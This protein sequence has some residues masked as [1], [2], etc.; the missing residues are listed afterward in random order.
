MEKPIVNILLELI[1]QYGVECVV[2]SPGS[3]NAALIDVADKKRE[4]KKLIVVD[5]RTAAFVA[6]GISLVSKSPVAVICTSGSALLN[7]APAVAEAYYQGIPLIVI[8]ADRPMEWIDQDDSQTIRQSGALSLITKAS[9]DLN[10]DE[11]AN[12]DYIWYAN[13]VINEGMIK[14][15]ERKSGPVHFNV[16]LD[17]KV[18]ES[19]DVSAQVQHP[20]IQNQLFRKV[21]VLRPAQRLDNQQMRQLA[22]EGFDKK[23]MVVAGFMQPDHRLQKAM[24]LLGT[25]PNVCIMAE[26]VSNLHLSPTCYKVDTV[27]FPMSG[28]YEE[29][30]RP[31]IVISLGGALISRKLKE[32]LRETN[33][34]HWSLSYAENLIDSFKTLTTKIEASPSTFIQTLSKLMSRM[35]MVA[36]L[37]NI[38]SYRDKWNKQRSVSE[39]KVDLFPWSDLK[40]LDL[41]LNSLP[42]ET[43]LFLSNG[44]SVRYGQ[45]LSYPLTHATYSNR[46]VSGIEGST[47]TA[48]GGSLVYDKLTCLITG[49]MSF[50]YDI[51]A[52][53][54]NLANNKMRII[55]LDNGGGDIF[56]FI[57]ATSNLEIREKYLCV[58]R[59]N[60]IEE[61]A[62]AYGWAYY[63]ASDEATL[64]S[65][66][67][68]F[69]SDLVVPAI[70]HVDTTSC[71]KNARTL[72]QFLTGQ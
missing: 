23:I 60:P 26:T 46:G 9:Y 8:S 14:A 43:N 39:K 13:R 44:T 51:G 6:L 53:G 25:L 40:A 3:R 63:Y 22:R 20:S 15:L 32:F 65:E 57:K 38:P 18:P 45:I 47:S 72:T 56:R 55:V 70:L 54:T 50:S 5:E 21:V 12:S 66:L 71:G 16:H 59:K 67:E 31:D 19:K 62:L 28:R 64:K 37:Q 52:F 42:E 69:F 34:L 61:I 17:G 2:C 29:E 68:E 10:G 24:A 36:G 1:R 41:V 33:A 4:L 58:N 49:D 35:Q 11:N 27:L 30:L 48:I 7:Y